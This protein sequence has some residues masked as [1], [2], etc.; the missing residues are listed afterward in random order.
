MGGVAKVQIQHESTIHFDLVLVGESPFMDVPF[1]RENLIRIP[2]VVDVLQ[3]AQNY[4]D[5]LS[6]VKSIVLTNS[7]YRSEDFFFTHPEFKNF[8]SELVQ[9]GLYQRYIKTQSLKSHFIVCN[10]AQ[11]R[12]HL[13][14]LGLQSLKEFV[15]KHPAVK[16]FNIEPKGL[17]FLRALHQEPKFSVYK[18]TSCGI[19][20][21]KTSVEITEIVQ[22]LKNQKINS[23]LNLGQGLSP[24]LQ[25]SMAADSILVFDFPDQDEKLKFIFQNQ[26]K[27]HS[28][29]GVGAIQ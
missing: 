12:G 1:L 26:N 4:W 20:N 24:A 9:F 28:K 16:T 8:L 25:N 6:G 13:L 3:R 23:A 5:S 29:S 10:T 18:L 15:Y 14:I 22:E 27:I 7:F 17:R 21:L 11:T 19:K 2:E